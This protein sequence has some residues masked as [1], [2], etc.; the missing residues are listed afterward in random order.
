MLDIKNKSDTFQI[1]GRQEF[2]KRTNARSWERCPGRMPGKDVIM[3]KY[4]QSPYPLI[5][6]LLFISIQKIEGRYWKH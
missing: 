4:E 1:L 6:F 3:R 2:S 5:K